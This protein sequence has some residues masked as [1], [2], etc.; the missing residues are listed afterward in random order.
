[1]PNDG[2]AERRGPDCA[3][4]VTRPTFGAQAANA[5]APTPNDE[6]ASRKTGTDDEWTSF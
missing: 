2:S 5:K 6:A 3:K 1:M 4:N